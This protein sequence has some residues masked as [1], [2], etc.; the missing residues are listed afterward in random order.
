MWDKISKKFA[1][2]Y[3][4]APWWKRGIVGP[5]LAIGILVAVAIVLWSVLI[6]PFKLFG[7]GGLLVWLVL[8]VIAVIEGIRG[9]ALEEKKKAEALI[10]ERKADRR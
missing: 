8:V 4:D 10:A 5:L 1:T 2:W 6:L 3:L 9:A 7:W